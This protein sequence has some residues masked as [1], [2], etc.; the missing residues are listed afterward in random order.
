MEKTAK[1][2]TSD[3]LKS[4]RDEN[5]P[6]GILIEGYLEQCLKMVKKEARKEVLDFVQPH[7]CDV[8]G[9][10]VECNYHTLFDILTK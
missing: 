8:N 2:M 6:L 1:E 7:D 3:I 5:N 10:I 9:N 4:L